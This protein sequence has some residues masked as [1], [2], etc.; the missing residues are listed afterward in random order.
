MKPTPEQFMKAVLKMA[1]MI[2]FF[3]KDEDDQK[4][5]SLSL[6]RFVNTDE[7]LDWLV[8]TACDAMRDWERGG[9]L[10]ELRGLFCTQ[11]KPADGRYEGCSTPSYQPA[12]LEATFFRKE[13][14]ENERRYEEY[15]RLAGPDAKAFPL[16]K[17]KLIQ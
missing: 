13:V 10:P 2:P 12:A 17:P 7:E 11:F 15:K 6:S 9:G 14:E 4:L 5:I 3:P 1:A 8:I 16:P